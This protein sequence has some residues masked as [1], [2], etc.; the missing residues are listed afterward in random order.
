MPN[1]DLV[2]LNN[3]KIENKENI[4]YC[5]NIDIKS[6]PEDLNK[7][8]NVTLIGRKVNKLIRKR[9]INLI[10]IKIS[11]NIFL[12]YLIFTKLSKKRCYL[13]NNFNNTIYF[14]FIYF[15]ILF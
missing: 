5:D 14:F 15:F 10:N 13:F 2:I 6:I 11:S 1:K 8:F 12:F 9:K 4:F 3:E 7:N